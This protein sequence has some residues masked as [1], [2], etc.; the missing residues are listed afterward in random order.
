MEE[1]KIISALIGLVGACNNNPKTENTDQVIIKAVAF[2]LIQ[3]EADAETIQ[4]LIEEI[5]AEKY[6]VAPGCATC[7]TPCG[8]TSDYDMDRIYNAEADI[9]NLKLKILSALKELAAELYSGQK[10]NMLSEETVEFFYKALSYIS[11]D[12][13][14]DSLL[15]FWNEVQETIEK[16]RRKIQE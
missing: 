3:P 2:P 15:T 7:Q 9:R 13:G 6:A 10:L 16:I 12:M 8:N 4:A 5:Y 11:F 1:N 14:I